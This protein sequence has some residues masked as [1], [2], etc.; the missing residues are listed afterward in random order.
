MVPV[1]RNKTAILAVD[2]VESLFGKGTLMRD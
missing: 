2:L 1:S